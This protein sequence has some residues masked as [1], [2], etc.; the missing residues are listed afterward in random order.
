MSDPTG[1]RFGL[2][3]VLQGILLLG[4]GYVTLGPFGAAVRAAEILYA[5]DFDRSGVVPAWFGPWYVAMRHSE[6]VAATFALAGMALIVAGALVM[7]RPAGARRWL[8]GTCWGALVCGSVLAIALVPLSI[9]SGDWPPA[10]PAAHVRR[11]VVA[12]TGAAWLAVAWLLATVVVLRR[13]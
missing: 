4:I 13:R 6:V 10:S 12:T 3:S 8:L 7:S 9:A 1:G 5:E 11:T 2:G